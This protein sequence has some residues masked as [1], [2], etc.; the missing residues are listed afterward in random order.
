MTVKRRKHEKNTNKYMNIL[1][2]IYI[3]KVHKLK[4][5]TNKSR[6]R[7]ICAVDILYTHNTFYIEYYV[8]MVRR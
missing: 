4:T 8:H 7:T 6:K 1:D 2:I 3:L 5:F